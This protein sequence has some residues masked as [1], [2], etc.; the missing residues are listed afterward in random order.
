MGVALLAGSCPGAMPAAPVPLQQGGAVIYDKLCVECHGKNGEGVKDKYDEPLH[1]NRTVEA[2]AKRIARTMPDDDVGACVGEDSKQVA[3]YIYDA[4]YSPKA[5]A[6][7]QPPDFDLARLT[8]AQYRTSVADLVG[9]FRPGFDKP[10][11]AIH[12][13]K[14]FYSGLVVAKPAL[15]AD[16]AAPA[17]MPSPPAK[18]DEKAKAPERT[19]F[20]RMDALIDFKFGAESPDPQKLASD[21][22][23]IRWE[24]SIFAPDTGTYEFIVKT[25]NGV[26]L[27]VNDTKTALIDGWVS[28]GP[29]IREMKKSLFLLGGRAYPI[30]VEFFKFQEK[31]ASLQLLWKPPHGVVQVIP[32]QRLSP[33]RLRET[34]VVKTTFPADDRSTGYE[35]GTG[36]S[37]EWDAATTGAA[38]EV[39]AH[40]DQHLEELAGVKP[41]AP[42]RVEKLKL[43][44]RHFAEAAFRRGLSEEDYQHFIVKH[45]KA[46]KTPEIAVKRVVLF[47]LKSP[48][49]LYPDLPAQG[50]PTDYDVAARLAL[51]LWDSI[52][53]QTLARA[54]AEGKLKTRDQIATQARRMITDAR[55]KAKL[56]GFFHHWLELERAEAISKDPKAFPSFDAAT[57]ADQRTSL[58]LFLDQVV[59]SEKSD[60]RELLEADYLMLNERLAKLYGKNVTGEEFQ[61]VE[62]DPKQRAGVVTHPYL[63]TALASSK[64]TS[65]IHRGVF[66]TRN[67]VGMTLKPPPM[68]V[69][70]EDSKFDPHLTMREK[71]TELTKN[72]SCMGCHA[73]I[74]PLGFSLENYDAIGR[75]RTKDNNKPINAASDFA[76]DEGEK[77]HLTGARDIVKFAAENPDGHRAFIHQLFQHTAKQSVNVYGPDTL[78]NLR[79]SFA[80]SGCNIRKLLTDISII[81]AARG[82]PEPPIKTALK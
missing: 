34:M 4:F 30:S 32:S 9:R 62:F 50:A 33:D 8:I 20:D 75:W 73:T 51:N 49:F 19:R 59:W 64:Q 55:T 72:N 58:Q 25:Q 70:F 46:A 40:V 27:S 11:G 23:S 77:I 57:L 48:R 78:E 61:R 42:D 2:L 63:L 52:P 26:R 39:L 14:G 13:L 16:P 41:S 31:S 1:G 37:K 68:A 22:F 7:L 79:Q 38:L 17:P 80:A 10:L 36:V 5:Q 28:S 3:A 6:R 56:A 45:F 12:G 66:L 53:D 69:A 54:A 43:F 29:E 47:T 21:E 18:K 82:M 44:A 76:T 65:P 74:N 60:Y 35:R 15:P 71:I 81:S 24:G 67:I